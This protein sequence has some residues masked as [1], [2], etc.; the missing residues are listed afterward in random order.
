MEQDWQAVANDALP[1]AFADI[2]EDSSR[3]EVLAHVTGTQQ[4]R[5]AVLQNSLPQTTAVERDH[6]SFEADW[7]GEP[8][9]ELIPTS[10]QND[11]VRYAINTADS[12]F[13]I[14]ATYYACEQGVWYE[15]LS[16]SGP[17]LVATEVP[18][19]I[20]AIPPSNPHHRVTYVRIYDVTPELVYVGYTPGYLGSYTYHGSIIYG[21]GHRYDPWV[22]SYYYPRGLTWGLSPFYDPWFGWRSGIASLHSPFRYNSAHRAR[23]NRHLKPSRIDRGQ[24]WQALRAAFREALGPATPRAWVRTCRGE[25]ARETANGLE[26]RQIG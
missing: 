3:S 22:G 26:S 15:S 21:T 4:A 25:P 14:G 12:V 11:E 6:V 16:A 9:F 2:A 23:H 10:N 5:R 13:K 24:T 1:V 8:Q 7:D 20:Y 17:W 18:S 19:I